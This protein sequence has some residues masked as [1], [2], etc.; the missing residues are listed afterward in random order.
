MWTVPFASR[1]HRWRQ[2]I[3]VSIGDLWIVLFAS[4]ILR[5]TQTVSV[6]IGNLWTI[7]SASRILRRAQTIGVSIDDLW[8]VP[9]GSGIHRWT[10]TIGVSIGDVGC[11]QFSLPLECTDR[12]K[13][14][15]FPS[16]M[17]DVNNS[18]RLWN[19]P[20]DSNPQCFHWWCAQWIIDYAC[21]VCLSS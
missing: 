16:V 9:F 7:P 19:T 2:T 1:I 15:V 11:E 5:R 18:L 17:W 13:P 6:S 3:S 20:M 14:S 21:I 4:G 10:Q 8:T 12:Y